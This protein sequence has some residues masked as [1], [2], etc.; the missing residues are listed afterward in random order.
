MS[1]NG[2]Y[3]CCLGFLAQPALDSQGS[4]NRTHLR[5]GRGGR[6]GHIFRVLLRAAWAHPKCVHARKFFWVLPLKL[7][8][9]G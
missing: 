4:G 8:T 3:G 7:P 5:S 1:Q 9:D 6:Y 2:K